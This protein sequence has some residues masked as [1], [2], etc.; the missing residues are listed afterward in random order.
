M[1]PRLFYLFAC[2]LLLLMLGACDEGVG[3]LVGPEEEVLSARSTVPGAEEA[4]LTER[5]Q[6]LVGQVKPLLTLPVGQQ[7][8]GIA[9]DGHG[10]IYV[11]N[12][13]AEGE[14]LHS[15]ILRVARDGS[16]S[17]FARLPET[18]VPGALGVLGLVTDWFG[19]VYAAVNTH[20]PATHG[21]WKIY[22]RGAH[23]ERLAGSENIAVPNALTFD[24]R[25]NLYVT[26]SFDGKVWQYGKDRAF[27]LWVEDDLLK[28]VEIPDAPIPIP[29]ANGIAFY[30]PNKLYVANTAQGSIVRAFIGKEGA[31]EGI[32][33]VVQDFNLFSIDG[34]AVDVQENLYAVMVSS[35]LEEINPPVVP[36]SLIKI[37]PNT[38]AI[39]PM[40]T[41][42]TAFDTPTSLAFGKDCQAGFREPQWRRPEIR[43]GQPFGKDCRDRQSVFIAN[44]SL[45]GPGLGAGPG[46]VQVGVGAPGYTL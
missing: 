40:V 42:A 36:P 4:L 10:N 41:D 34:I 12:R 7:P 19:N 1:K 8:E 43:E 46:I 5:S 11:G 45:F 29:G 16:V 27:S 9:I 23:M 3:S 6:L 17:V 15:E 44:A 18:S 35:T 24:M 31:V 13:Q 38:G 28:P 32:E 26:D 20:E 30:P 33:M 25:G 14:T 21:V 39:T 37:D 22:R 2:S